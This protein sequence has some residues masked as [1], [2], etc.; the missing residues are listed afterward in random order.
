[1]NMPWNAVMGAALW[2][3]VG[4]ADAGVELQFRSMCELKRDSDSILYVRVEASRNLCP[5]GA[6]F[7]NFHEATVLGTS[8]DHLDP[9]SKERTSFVSL[10]R[11]SVGATYLVFAKQ[12]GEPKRIRVETPMLEWIEVPVP[13]ETQYFVPL[14]GAFEVDFKGLARTVTKYCYG[15][16]KDCEAFRAIE[17]TGAWSAIMTYPGAHEALAACEAN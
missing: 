2:L 12:Y 4:K 8:R 1:M 5:E 14:D 16:G 10:T 9:A 13:E 6:C 7:A 11:V 3:A 15:D 17:E